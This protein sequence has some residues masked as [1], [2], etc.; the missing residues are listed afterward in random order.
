MKELI[1]IV[2]IL[3][4]TSLGAQDLLEYFNITDKEK[5]KGNIS[6]PIG[7]NI[8]DALIIFSVSPPSLTL[9]ITDHA[10]VITKITKESKDY[11]VFVKSGKD[12]TLEVSSVGF[13]ITKIPIKNIESK[14]TYFYL[15]KKAVSLESASADA[16]ET[17]SYLCQQLELRYQIYNTV[18]EKY[19]DKLAKSKGKKKQKITLKMLN[20]I[21]ENTKNQ[22]AKMQELANKYKYLVNDYTGKYLGTPFQSVFNENLNAYFDD[23]IV[24]YEKKYG[25]KI[26]R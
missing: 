7:I 1:F 23:C 26:T 19:S 3:F 13:G 20:E 14:G 4:S 25:Y 8:S 22:N 6:I 10:N 16:K 21:D 9:E 5:A 24:N 2:L 11:K 17:A 18:N 12:I 15:I